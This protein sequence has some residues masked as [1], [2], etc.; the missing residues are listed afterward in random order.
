[1]ANRTSP[2][3]AQDRP[4]VVVVGGGFGGLYTVRSLA[5]EPVDVILIDRRNFHTFQPLLY[6]VATGALSPGDIASPLRYAVKRQANTRVLMG[7]V[8]GLDPPGRRVILR[9]GE[10]PYDTLVLAAGVVNAYFGH[11]GWRRLAP[12]LKEIED[13]LD[14]RRRVLSAF[15]AAEREPDLNRR[16][17]WLTFVVVG[18][19]PTGV[20][21]AGA[22]GELA[23]RTLAGEFRVVD[24]RRSRVVLVEGGDRILPSF[25]P[26]LSERARR[27]LARLGVEVRSGASVVGVDAGGVDLKG[28]AA[29]ERLP[30]RTT[31]WAAGVHASPLARVLHEATRCELDP[32]GRVRVGAD[33]TVPGHPEIFVVG[34]MAHVPFQDAPL[35]AVAP[36]AIQEAR[37]AARLIGARVRGRP[38]PGPFRYVD[39]GMMATIGRSAAV[40][41]RG[42]LRIAG[43][44]AWLA[45]L[46]IHLLYLI[47]FENRVL[48]LIQWV[49]TY[50]RSRRGARLIIPG[51]R[52]S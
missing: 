4:R 5:R 36:A 35:P 14:I 40:A 44:P 48:V 41:E 21:L 26:S 42:R 46:F 24:P 13:A 49:N 31:L 3:Q 37:Y 11:D 16:E 27:S 8:V 17:A 33:L 6:Q 45:W 34:D 51:E 50:F 2:S 30:A 20:E 19:G 39:K 25:S 43:V 38:T 47:E 23:H 12:G 29:T 22:L 28:P 10:V 32:M 52:L 15:E 18:G 7:E 1:M 9:D